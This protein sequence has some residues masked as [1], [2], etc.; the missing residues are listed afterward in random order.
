MKIRERTI[1]YK[2]FKSLEP[3]RDYIGAY[4]E[5]DD[6]ILMYRETPNE[7]TYLRITSYPWYFCITKKDRELKKVRK[8][9]KERKLEGLIQKIKGDGDYIKIFCRNVNNRRVLD[10]KGELLRELKQLKIRTYEADLT[11]SQRC[12]LDNNLQVAQKYK[13]LYFD[14]ETDDRGEKIVIGERRIVSIAAVNQD[15]REYYYSYEKEKDILKKWYDLVAKYDI[16]TGW[17]SENFDIPYIRERAKLNRVWSKYGKGEIHVDMMNKLKEIHKR[18]IELIKK[19][20]SFSLNA[21]AKEFLG[22]QKVEHKE[23]IYEMFENNPKLLKKYNIQ[24][25]RLVKRIDDRLRILRQ[26]IIEHGI[27]GNF[28]NFYAISRILDMYIL[29]NAP[30]GVRFRTKPPYSKDNYDQTESR[31]SGGAVLEPTPGRHD[32]VYHFDFTSLYPSIIRTW[33]ISPETVSDEG[34][35]TPNGEHFTEEPGIIPTTIQGLLDARNNIRHNKMKGMTEEDPQ[36]EELYFKQY[37]FKTMSNSFY[38]ILGASFTRYYRK[39][40]AEAITLSGQ[41]LIKLITLF[42]EQEGMNVLYGDT[43]SVFVNGKEIDPEEFH[44]RV[45]TFIAYHLFRHFNIKKSYIDLK[46]EAVYDNVLLLDKKKRYVK[47]EGGELHIV[48]L[49]ARR[50]ETIPLAAKKQVEMLEMILLKNA[51]AKDMINWV[52]DFKNLVTSGELTAEEVTA[53]IKLSKDCEKYDKYDEDGELV[54]ESKLPHVKVAKWLRDN[55]MEEDGMKPWEKG[56]YIKYI[57]TS[58]IRGQGINAVSPLNYEEG[59]YDVAY[60]WNTKFYRML[61]RILT[62][63]FPEH[64]WKQYEID[65]KIQRGPTKEEIAEQKIRIKR[66]RRSRRVNR[67]KCNDSF[68]F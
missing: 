34:I 49:E 25:C 33:N 17:N 60:Y 42:F 66:R 28:L 24:D 30:K 6:V 31:Y 58:K 46:V 37:A 3:E 27:T 20:R 50:R 57:V 59:G 43:D 39:E 19:V 10:G 53:Q 54:T 8:W 4:D 65:T 1:S 36:Y 29:R 55:N 35:L 56:G 62:V 26:K 40:N 64:D 67:R 45:N 44:Q 61:E 38:G 68:S 15:G 63:V 51:Q 52:L 14:I 2:Y 23:G 16:I 48:G 13:I 47:N 22:E 5:K 12:V 41:Y 21:V 7:K 11:S 9:I 18:N 32:Q